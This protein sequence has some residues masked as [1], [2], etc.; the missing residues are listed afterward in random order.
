[1]SDFRGPSLEV[2]ARYL[3]A[4][5]P[6]YIL[7]GFACGRGHFLPPAVRLRDQQDQ[8]VFWLGPGLGQ[9]HQAVFLQSNSIV[10]RPGC[11]MK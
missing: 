1:M 11:E 5:E 2:W 8:K 3:E 7:P 6:L 4:G 9:S 10:K